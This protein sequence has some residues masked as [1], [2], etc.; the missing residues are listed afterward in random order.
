MQMNLL[1]IWLNEFPQNAASP[2]AMLAFACAPVNN[3]IADVRAGW[4]TDNVT[5]AKVQIRH[6]DP[7]NR[8]VWCQPTKSSAIQTGSRN[9]TD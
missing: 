4:F 8:E 6:I 7:M 9:I 2:A 1:K 3:E 5:A